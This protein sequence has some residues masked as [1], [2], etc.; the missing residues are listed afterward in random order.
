MSEGRRP[1]VTSWVLVGAGGHARVLHDVVVRA[2]GTVLAV[3]GQAR[4]PAWEVPVLASDDDLARRLREGGASLGLGIG[5][6]ASRARAL[7]WADAAGLPMPP[8]L[9]AT[10]TIAASALLGDGTVVLEHAHVGPAARLGRGVVVNTGAVVEHDAGVGDGSHVAPRAV[11][12]G[13]AE[14]GAGTLVGSGA[15]VLPGVRVGSGVTVGAGAVVTADVPDGAVVV[16][17]PARAVADQ[18]GAR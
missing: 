3:S 11:V 13:G 4:G 5:D 8:L 17:V 1:D 12:L 9:A 6:E 18:R 2:G 16:G 15:T 14:V 7:A 10:A